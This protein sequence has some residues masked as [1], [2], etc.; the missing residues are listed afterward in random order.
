[1]LRDNF[2]T[3]Y[4]YIAYCK[5]NAMCTFLLGGKGEFMHDCL[6]ND[7]K[8][9]NLNKLNGYIK[10]ICRWGINT[11]VIRSNIKECNAPGLQDSQ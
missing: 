10:V 4:L 1:M 5:L 9:N 7:F 6:F 8:K 11:E 3:L 2:V